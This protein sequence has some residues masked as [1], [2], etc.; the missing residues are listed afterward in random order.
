MIRGGAAYDGR[1]GEITEGSKKK[2]LTG[3]K[4]LLRLKLEPIFLVGRRH[5]L[6]PKT[7]Q[8]KKLYGIFTHFCYILMPEFL[9]KVERQDT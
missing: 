2:G 9:I 4:P 3:G 6:T 1:L 5:T 7:S 8:Y